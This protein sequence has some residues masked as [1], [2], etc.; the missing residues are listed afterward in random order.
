MQILITFIGQ[1]VLQGRFYAIIRKHIQSKDRSFYMA[2]YKLTVAYD[3]TR[4]RGWQR[5][6][7]SEDTIQGKLESVLSRMTNEKIQVIGAG[8]TDGGAH[9]RGQ[10]ANFQSKFKATPEEF[11]KYLTAYLP[12]DIAIISVEKAAPRFHARFNAVSRQ[13]VYQI[14]TGVSPNP[15][16]NKYRLHVPEKL[17]FKSME[18]ACERFMG[19][20]DFQSFTSRKSKTKSNERTITRLELVR[21]GNN[22]DIIFEADGF[23]HNMVRII[24]GTIL[25]VGLGKKTPSD[26]DKIFAENLRASA[27]YTVSPHGLFLEEVMFD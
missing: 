21:D 3:G 22:L 6:K 14:R 19:T 24:T 11:F 26:I 7:D 8:R 16:D 18:Q 15:F 4:Y 23:L 20:H 27:G 1:Y 5:L 25:E 17:N 9:A 12:K 2:N 13:Y 10:V